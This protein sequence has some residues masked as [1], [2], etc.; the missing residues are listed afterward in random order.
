MTD[1]T[2]TIQ[3]GEDER[4]M[5]L[6]ALG[7][8]LVRLPEG[9]PASLINGLIAKMTK[10]PGQSDSASQGAPL[11]QGETNH[12]LR[13]YFQR[14][15]KG[16]ELSGPPEGAELKTLKIVG[17]QEMASKTPGKNPF[18]KVLFT[19]GQAACFDSLL[20]PHIVKRTGE[21]AALYFVKS[22]NYWNIVGVRA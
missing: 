16:N 9:E 15:R 4:L 14:D 20:F 10:A 2:F 11:P 5:N 3:M 17:A 7:F 8:A 6:A 22:G 12:A 18:L 13:D 19:G 1:R 21:E